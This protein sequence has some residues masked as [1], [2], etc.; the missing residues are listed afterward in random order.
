[1]LPIGCWITYHARRNWVVRLLGAFYYQIFVSS[2]GAGRRQQL[3]HPLSTN[4]EARQPFAPLH[5]CLVAVPGLSDPLRHIPCA[6][7]RRTLPT[8]VKGRLDVPRHCALARTTGRR[9]L[10]DCA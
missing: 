8:L 7:F 9:I 1:V 2:C 4:P 5:S 6:S 10:E 3:L